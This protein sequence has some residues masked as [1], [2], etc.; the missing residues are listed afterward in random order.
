[1][2]ASL[3]ASWLWTQCGQPHHAPDS[4][5]S[6]PSPVTPWASRNS[7]PLKLI[8]FR[9]LTTAK[10]AVTSTSEEVTIPGVRSTLVI[11]SCFWGQIWPLLT[12]I[13]AQ[14]ETEDVQIMFLHNLGNSCACGG[15]RTALGV[16]PC[17]PP[18]L[19]Q[20]LLLFHCLLQANMSTDS[21]GSLVLAS[22]LL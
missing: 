2:R 14:V 6:L 7:F 3:P 17:I 11:P 13:I 20:G 9:Y 5:T 8:Q 10:G 22:H 19:R 21:G 16:E 12:P 1:M 18:C 4:T 15:Q